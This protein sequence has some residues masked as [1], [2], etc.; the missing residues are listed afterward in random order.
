MRVSQ[1]LQPRRAQGAQALKRLQA[2]KD[3]Q[4][5]Q[6]LQRGTQIQGSQ[7]GRFSTASVEMSLCHRSE[8]QKGCQG[9]GPGRLPFPI[10]PLP[11]RVQVKKMKTL[12]LISSKK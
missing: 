8:L 1:F 2:S 5:I 7:R 10:S 4:Q 12:Q 3:H 6:V 11:S 9:P